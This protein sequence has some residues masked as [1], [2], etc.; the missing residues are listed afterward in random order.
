MGFG[1]AEQARRGQSILQSNVCLMVN[2]QA[3]ADSPRIHPLYAR[4]SLQLGCGFRKPV[5]VFAFVRNLETE[6]SPQA[7]DDMSG[8]DTH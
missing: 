5:G 1:D 7:M 4:H 8:W 3:A 6:P 2:Q